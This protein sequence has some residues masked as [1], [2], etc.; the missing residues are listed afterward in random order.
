MH[1]ITSTLPR[2]SRHSAGADPRK[3]RVP[4]LTKQP[5]I[6][7]TPMSKAILRICPTRVPGVIPRLP[8]LVHITGENG[9]ACYYLLPNL[10][11]YLP[12]VMPSWLTLTPFGLPVVPKG[13]VST[14]YL[15]SLHMSYLKYRSHTLHRRAATGIV[16]AKMQLSWKS[17]SAAVHRGMNH[18]TEAP[19]H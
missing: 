13:N 16:A 8:G 1:I 18:R 9:Q 12:F 6:S 5:R 11:S 10:T 7:Q 4:P 19:P 17:D 15:A 2:V 3:M 14:I